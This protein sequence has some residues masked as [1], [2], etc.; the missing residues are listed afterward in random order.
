MICTKFTGGTCCEIPPLIFPSKTGE[1]SHEANPIR[2]PPIKHAFLSA[3][4]ATLVTEKLVKKFSFAD[5]ISAPLLFPKKPSAYFRITIDLR[6]PT[7]STKKDE[8]HMPNKE[9]MLLQAAGPKYFGEA[10]PV[11]RYFQTPLDP[12]DGH[13]HTFSGAE[14]N[15]LYEPARAL[16]GFESSLIH[17]QV[18]AAEMFAKVEANIL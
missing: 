7:F 12:V 9:A 15:S 18:H 16:K 10:D 13:T 11:H 4:C 8:R 3:F 6:P 2:Y 17:M 14:T 5:W 1:K